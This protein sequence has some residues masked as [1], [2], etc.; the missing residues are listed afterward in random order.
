[1]NLCDEGC[2]KTFSTKA[3]LLR[4]KANG[5]KGKSSLQCSNCKKMFEN[6][7]ARWRHEATVKCNM[8]ISPEEKIRLNNEELA[9]ENKKY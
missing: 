4:H 7:K 3:N 6:V 1:M 8:Y 2:N 9:R 5:C